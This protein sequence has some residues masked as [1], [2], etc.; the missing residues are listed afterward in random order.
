MLVFRHTA[1]IFLFYF[2]AQLT[3]LFFGVALPILIADLMNCHVSYFG[4]CVQSALAFATTVELLFFLE[5]T[6]AC[7]V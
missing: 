4:A 6:V 5:T 7:H 3:V 2:L 1:W